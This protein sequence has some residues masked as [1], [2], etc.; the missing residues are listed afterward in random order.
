MP[1][2]NA[3]N[4]TREGGVFGNTP[5][6]PNV[7]PAALGN[8]NNTVQQ[9]IATAPVVAPVNGPPIEYQKDL[10]AWEN[11]SKEQQTAEKAFYAKKAIERQEAINNASQMFNRVGNQPSATEINNANLLKAA[12]QEEQAK[13][14]AQFR[15][16]QETDNRA[17][18]CSGKVGRARRECMVGL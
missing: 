8:F 9:G 1:R 11:L 15:A 4:I 13:I 10:K 3:A 7:V 14:A 6:A 5:L 12:Q 2:F 17:K 16:Q 18:L